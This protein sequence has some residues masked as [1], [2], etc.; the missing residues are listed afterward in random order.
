MKLHIDEMMR[1]RNFRVRSDVVERISHQESKRK[2]SLL[3]EESGS[4]FS[5]RHMDNVPE[6]THVVSV[7][8]QKPIGNSGKGQR[9]KGRS[10]SL[11]SHSEAKQTEGEG[12]KSSKGSCNKQESS[13]D[14]SEIPCR[15]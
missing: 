1:T 11:A 6:E 13:L 4:V 7:M 12:Q 15:F 14:K 5:G 9:Q 10:S 3:R 2:E 8:T